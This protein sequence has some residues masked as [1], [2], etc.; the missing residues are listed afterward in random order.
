[1]AAACIRFDKGTYDNTNNKPTISY[2]KAKTKFGSLSF[3]FLVMTM[4][5]TVNVHLSMKTP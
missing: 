1:M 3:S 4:H 5:E 2:S